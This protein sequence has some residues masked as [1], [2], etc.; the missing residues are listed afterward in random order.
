MLPRVLEPEVMDTADDARDYDAMDFVA[1]NTAFAEAALAVAPD[2]GLVLDLGTGTARI[3]LLMVARRPTLHVVGIDLSESMLVIARQHL[4]AAGPYACV[5][6]RR[7]DAKATGFPDGCFDMVI[8]NSI[9]HHLPEPLAVFR[10]LA[11]V[12]SPW[13]ALFLRDLLRPATEAEH[14]HLVATYCANDNPHQRQLFS[15]SLRAAL[16]L[17]EVRALAE[18][19]GLADFTLARTS[20]RHWT[21]S[22]SH[23]WD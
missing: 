3:P 19:A 1:V 17:D 15:D 6:V 2:E 16:T 4:A 13:A 21:L 18:Q 5:E 8:S 12:A 14:A 20:D 11:R 9:V 10:E 7:L 23:K 22:R